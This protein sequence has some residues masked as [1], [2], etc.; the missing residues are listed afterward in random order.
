M[1]PL[2]APD[3]FLMKGEEEVPPAHVGR[4]PSQ[5]DAGPGRAERLAKTIGAGSP[6]QHGT[7]QARR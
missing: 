6:L 7:S 4:K 2:L 5:R 3:S 1:A